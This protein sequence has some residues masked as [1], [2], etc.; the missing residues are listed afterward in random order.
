MLF[1]QYTR[2]NLNLL[3]F[4]G[5]SDPYVKIKS[6]GRLLYKSRIISRDLNPVWDEIVILP[7]EDPFQPIY[8]KVTFSL[9]YLM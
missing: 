3:L 8:F 6:N 9:I 1:N 2:E 7:I 5:F 4:S